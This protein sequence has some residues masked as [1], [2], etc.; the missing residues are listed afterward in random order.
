MDDHG[1]LY[2]LGEVIARTS[3]WTGREVFAARSSDPLLA[4]AVAVDGEV[5]VANLTAERRRIR[6][7]DVELELGAYAVESVT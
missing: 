3:G 2:P 7:H 5:L 1:R 6:V 4:Q